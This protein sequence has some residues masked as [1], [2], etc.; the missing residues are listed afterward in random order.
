MF[1]VAD[2]VFDSPDGSRKT[3]GA[4]IDAS[5]I[6]PGRCDKHYRPMDLFFF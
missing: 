1:H 4:G 6:K 5:N 3:S 2:S